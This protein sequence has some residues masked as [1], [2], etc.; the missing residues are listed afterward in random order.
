M[1]AIG[2]LHARQLRGNIE[3]PPRRLHAVPIHH[4]AAEARVDFERSSVVVELHDTVEDVLVIVIVGFYAGLQG[5]VPKV[6]ELSLVCCEESV[7]RFG[8]AVYR[9]IGQL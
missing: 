5:L 9:S 2:L 3:F 8:I 7:E 6:I 1:P 4:P